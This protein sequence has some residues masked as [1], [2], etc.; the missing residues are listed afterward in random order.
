MDVELDRLELKISKFLRVGV[1][2]AGALMATG[3]I[4]NVL[5]G[6][7][8]VNLLEHY[9]NVSL[10]RDWRDSVARG[11]WFRLTSYVGLFVLISL[12]FTRVVLT[13]VLFVKQR[14]WVLAAVAG[15]VALAL[16][17]SVVMGIE[18]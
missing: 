13:A 8:S 1:L 4:A 7:G 9:A 16:V 15:F 12:P 18:L 3:W 6:A 2:V 14:E 5:A 17:G 11:D 10:N